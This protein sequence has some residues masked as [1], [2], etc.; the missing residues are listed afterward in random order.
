MSTFQ[1]MLE[2]EDTN[3]DMAEDKWFYTSSLRPRRCHLSALSADW[4][5]QLM[6]FDAMKCHSIIS[7]SP[8]LLPKF[9]RIY[10][11]CF[12]LKGISCGDNK[13]VN[14]KFLETSE[15]S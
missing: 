3:V 14:R 7:I 12:Q 10:F 11:S 5:H 13:Y 8:P 6:M 15:T 9:S 1:E 4:I 2:V